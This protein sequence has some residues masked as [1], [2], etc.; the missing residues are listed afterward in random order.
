VKT[1]HKPRQSI[2]KKTQ[3]SAI[4]DLR[5]PIIAG[6]SAAGLTIGQSIDPLLER[7]SPEATEDLSICLKYSFGPVEV[8]VEYGRIAQIGL[9]SGY[10]GKIKNEISVGSSVVAVE[11][12]LGPI[13]EDDDGNSVIAGSS[14]L[15]LDVQN[16][17]IAGI[18]VFG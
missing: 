7:Q 12:V 11:S 17:T 10:R 15:C 5:A 13:T 8:W 16:K 18:Y 4:L 1:S 14:G 6:K 2:L 9:R 3:P